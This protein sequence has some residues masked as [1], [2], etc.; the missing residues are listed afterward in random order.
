M[1]KVSRPLVEVRTLRPDEFPAAIGLLARAFRDEP[2]QIASLG[3][4]PRRRHQRLVTLFTAM[5]G[6]MEGQVPLAALDGGALVGVSGVAPPGTCQPTGVQLLKY[7]PALVAIGP[8][9]LL[10]TAQLNRSWAAADPKEQH[11]HLGPLAVDADLR[12]RGI[13]SQILSHYCRQLDEAKVIGYL[14]TDSEDKVRLYRRFGFEVVRERQ[15]I[16]VPNWFMVRP[17]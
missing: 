6:V 3:P 5:F 2:L 14:E 16:G 17:T 8:R 12:G 1:V 15:V 7:V 11:S 9:S 4:D 10:R 13:G